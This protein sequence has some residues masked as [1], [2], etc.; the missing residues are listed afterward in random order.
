VLA[1]C[2]YGVDED[3]AMYENE[4]GSLNFHSN[5]PGFLKKVVVVL[6]A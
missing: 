4:Q 2:T 3:L 1:G 6:I 5:I